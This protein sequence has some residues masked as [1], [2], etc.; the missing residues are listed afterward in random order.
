[1]K[2]L[3]S[4]Y[5]LLV[6]GWLLLVATGHAQSPKTKPEAAKETVAVFVIKSYES[7]RS[8]DSYSTYDSYTSSYY[9]D[10]QPQLVPNLQVELQAAIENTQKWTVVDW[11]RLPQIISL[12]DQMRSG[13]FDPETIGR[14]G[15]LF[16]V[17]WVIYVA[18]EHFSVTS[19]LGVD[20]SV[21]F[22]QGLEAGFRQITV[23]LR[24]SAWM[25]D[26]ERGIVRN[27]IRGEKASESTQV[28]TVRVPLDRGRFFVTKQL[29]VSWL[30]AQPGRAT[31]L[32]AG[33][34]AAK[35][36]SADLTSFQFKPRLLVAKVDGKTIFLNQGEAAG[37]KIGDK[38]LA[39]S[40]QEVRDPDSG[41]LLGHT[42]YVIIQ[43]ISVQPAFA[44]A[45]VIEGVGTIAVGSE[46]TPYRSD[47]TANGTLST[48]VNPVGSFAEP[49][50][51]STSP[52]DWDHQFLT[53]YGQTSVGQRGIIYRSDRS[54]IV[55]RFTVVA[56]VKDGQVIKSGSVGS[57]G[58]ICV[59]LDDPAGYAKD[60]QDRWHCD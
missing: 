1:M 42:D 25:V 58:V 14:T 4:F 34:L 6:V 48:P 31:R 8:Y 23:T 39:A 10:W 28:G 16:G 13:R 15:K 24:C 18:I 59:K 56:I 26:V 52:Q 27:A 50:T 49:A 30:K 46:L 44:T 60:P 47:R 35:L 43:T 33:Q 29:G 3:A 5:L 37:I 17:R 22:N 53:E 45:K 9:S 32:M 51:K 54:N 20:R 2:R 21:I 38:F 40:G 55:A 7:Y 36:T 57:G 11:Q 19:G 41:Q 12:Q